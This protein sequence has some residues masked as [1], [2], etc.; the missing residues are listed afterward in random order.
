MSTPESAYLRSLRAIRPREVAEFQQR[1]DNGTYR[2]TP[3]VQQL[4]EKALIAA[5]GVHQAGEPVT[6]EAIR[7]RDPELTELQVAELCETPYFRQALAAR[8]IPGAEHLHHLTGE[9]LTVLQVMTDMTVQTPVMQ[10]LKRLGVSYKRWQGWLRQPVFASAY[11]D[12][13]SKLGEDTVGPITQTLRG[14]ALDGDV[15]AAKLVLELDG[16][17][18]PGASQ[19][20]ADRQLEV[21][22]QRFQQA[23]DLFITDDEQRRQIAH[24]L[25]TGETVAGELVAVPLEGPDAL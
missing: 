5:W 1:R 22:L 20:Q 14:K 25:K 10:R 15:N 9:Q 23:F 16:V 18:S 12:L 19:A 2:D 6:P 4:F 24:F 13:L 8:G 17:Y 21:V 3:P 11:Q 7:Q